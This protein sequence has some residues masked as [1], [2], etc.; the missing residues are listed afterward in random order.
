LERTCF[1]ASAD[2]Q[3]YYEGVPFVNG[4]PPAMTM[5]C[6]TSKATPR[7]GRISIRNIALRDVIAMAYD[8][9][10]N[11]IPHTLVGGPAKL[12]EARFDIEAKP[13]EGAP[14]S[15]TL[16]MLRTLLADRFKL[17]THTEKRN[18]PGYALV[19]ARDGRLGPKLQPS[20]IDCAAPA[21]ATNSG[22]SLPAAERLRLCPL[23]IYGF[24]TPGP[25]DLTM[26]DRSSLGHM[27]TR[28]QP[29]VERPLVDATGLTGSFAWSL[30]FAIRTDSTTAP[31]VDAA[32]QE[33]L[34][35]R[36]DRRTAPFD[37]LVVDSVEMPTPN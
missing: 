5:W 6:M 10:R 31:V 1:E 26:T 16:A 35:I 37:V 33:Q 8:I 9:H 24:D 27:L 25:G 7:P 28:V 29:F 23:N 12:M 17:R 22:R 13:P 4:W 2:C 34:G 14:A 18:I 19:I 3:I 32:F 20:D 21:S 30:S 15:E 11:L 36:L